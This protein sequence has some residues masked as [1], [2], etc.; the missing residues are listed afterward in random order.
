MRKLGLLIIIIAVLTVPVGAASFTAPEISNPYMPAEVDDF[1][2]GLWFVVKTAIQNLLP[3]VRDAGNICLSII[4]VGMLIS[5][6]TSA[7]AFN[8][9]IA[10]TVGIISVSVL[11]FQSSNTFIQTGITTVQE[12][13]QY[14]K[15]L[16]P[17][18]TAALAATGGA[19]TSA[20]LYTGTAIF[21]YCLTA[22][23][24]KLVVPLIYIYL[25]VS[26]SHSIAKEELLNSIKKFI[27]WLVQWGLKIVI[28]IFT[29]YLGITGVI[30][31]TVDASALKATKLAISG[32]VPVVG[33][34]IS[35][36]SE[37]ILVSAG[38]MKN[39]AGIYGGLAI[40]AM[41]IGPFLQIGIQYLLLKITGF[42]CGALQS[43]E[44]ADIVGDFTTALGFVLG[45][46]VTICVLLLIS[47]VCFMKG[48]V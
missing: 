46:I 31:G 3:E 18:M 24:T 38:L 6:V 36:A 20:A 21:N 34:T 16:L 47:T 44:I 5:L 27:K 11:L 39:A 45:M 42:I 15:L 29:G 41:W 25:C 43:K 19:T 30:S 48:V 32:L 2:D 23:L 28:Y 7:F 14:G 33:S 12:L 10:V 13:S 37:T 1:S 9:Q 40:I 17:V 8:K 22:V 35:D 26:I 4:A